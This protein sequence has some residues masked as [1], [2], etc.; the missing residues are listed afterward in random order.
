MHVGGVLVLEAPPGGVEALAALVEARLPLVP[1]YRQRVAEVPG[2]PG[3]SGVGR[4]PGLRPRL[5]PPP[6]RAAAAGHRGAAAGPGVPADLASAGP[7]PAALG[8]LPGGG[9]AG[10]PGGGGD[11]D[12]PGAGRRAQRHRHRPGAAR[13]RAG[14]A[15]ART[16]SSGS[17]QRPPSGA[18]LVLAGARRV[19]PPPVVGRGDR[20]RGG[21]PTSGR[22][23]PASAGVAGG[24]LRTARAGGAPGAAQPAERAGRAAAAGGGGAGRAR[25]R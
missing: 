16:R 24:L 1:R 14:R 23:R 15:G 11:Q 13:R 3:Q 18:E 21:R 2:P 6:V 19:R 10:R 5:P 17:P 9:P 25:R 8:G 22:R 4:R 12:P 7:E 20:P